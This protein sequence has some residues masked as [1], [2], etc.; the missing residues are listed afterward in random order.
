MRKKRP[1]SSS[2]RN[3]VLKDHFRLLDLYSIS[4]YSVSFGR[5]LDEK[6]FMADAFVLALV[7]Y[8]PERHRPHDHCNK[9]HCVLGAQRVFC[10]N[11]CHH[12]Q[13]VFCWQTVWHKLYVHTVCVVTLSEVR[14]YQCSKF[15]NYKYCR[16]LNDWFL[17]LLFGKEIVLNALWSK[18]IIIII[19]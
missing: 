14:L 12:F 9:Y 7:M 6:S 1:F 16:A 13:G 19:D 8:E 5:F 17:Y 18:H 2:T 10:W 3:Y 4:D 11:S 15:V